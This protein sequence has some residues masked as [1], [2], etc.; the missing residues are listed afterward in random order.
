MSEYIYQVL[1]K[2]MGVY[3]SLLYLSL[4]L[5]LLSPLSLCSLLSLFLF[6]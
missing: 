2:S 5:S 4:S 1:D 3:E 6:I